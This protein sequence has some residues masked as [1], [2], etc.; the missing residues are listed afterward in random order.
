MLAMFPE[1]TLSNL[2][3]DSPIQGEAL[4]IFDEVSKCLI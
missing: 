3:S 1:L 4:F 2:T